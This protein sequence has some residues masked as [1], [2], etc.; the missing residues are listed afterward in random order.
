MN[1][2]G[3]P[4]L[5]FNYYDFLLLAVMIIGLAILKKKHLNF[6]NKKL[7]IVFRIFFLFVFIP[8][9]SM[10]IEINNV[11]VKNGIDDSFT[12]LYTLFKIPIWWL[13]G[14]ILLFFISI[15]DTREFVK[16]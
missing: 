8:Y 13:I 15:L 7:V 12:L 2:Q 5:L 3:T 9:L 6:I 4:F 10:Q 11:V 1:E 16:E 14:M